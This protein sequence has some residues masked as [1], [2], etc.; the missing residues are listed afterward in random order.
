MRFRVKKQYNKT[1]LLIVLG[2]IENSHYVRM[3][4]RLNKMGEVRKIMDNMYVL[5]IAQIEEV[6]LATSMVRNKI[7]GDDYGYCFVIRITNELSCAWSLTKLNS[8]YL[9]DIIKSLEDGKKE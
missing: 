2:D 1:Y 7:T 5:S 6:K 4:E 8:D 3:L 9:I